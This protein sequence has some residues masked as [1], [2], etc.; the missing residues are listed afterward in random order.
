MFLDS[1]SD[2]SEDEA[3]IARWLPGSGAT[4]DDGCPS[5]EELLA[6]L[7]RD[8]ARERERAR[9]SARVAEGRAMASIEELM[10]PGRGAP[11]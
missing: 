8:E 3:A 9:P 11:P 2:S 10:R 1:V 5:L 4:A 6:R 7:D